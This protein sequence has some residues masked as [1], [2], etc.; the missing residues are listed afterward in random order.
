MKQPKQKFYEKSFSANRNLLALLMIGL[1]VLGIVVIAIVYFYTTKDSKVDAG[2]RIFSALLPMFATWVGTILAFYFGKENFDAASQ[3]YEQLITKLSP[4]LL[5]DIQVDQIMIDTRTMVTMALKEANQKSVEELVEFMDLVSKSRLPII[6][7][8]DQIVYVIHKST[9]LA[10]M[11]KNT[12]A[13]LTFANFIANKENEQISKSFITV[14]AE[15]IL[16]TVQQ[17]LK[18]NSGVK[19]IFVVGANKKVLGWLTDTLILQYIKK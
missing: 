2:E 19:D 6:N 14:E 5:D 8:K 10:A 12:T 13:P 17:R 15:T 4:E 3:R 9:F 11:Q 16:E 1:T 18:G 7:D